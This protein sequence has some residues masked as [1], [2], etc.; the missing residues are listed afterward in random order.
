MG[1]SWNWNNRRISNGCY[2]NKM[3]SL[4]KRKYKKNIVKEARKY[5]EETYQ[6]I[7]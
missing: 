1:C 3:K 2:N 4:L 6:K 5:A 7:Q